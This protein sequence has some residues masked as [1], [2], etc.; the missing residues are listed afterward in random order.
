MPDPSY[1]GYTTI[2]GE[3]RFLFDG[4][5]YDPPTF[6]KRPLTHLELYY[7]RRVSSNIMNDPHLPEELTTAAR[8]VVEKATAAMVERGINP[9]EMP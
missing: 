1:T 5:I 6:T 7:V 3:Q 8:S 9:E 4:E 2:D